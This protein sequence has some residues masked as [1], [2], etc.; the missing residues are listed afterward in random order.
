MSMTDTSRAAYERYCDAEGIDT[1]RADAHWKAWAKL[2]TNINNAISL[3]KG[4]VNLR[5][6]P[7]G[8]FK[9]NDDDSVVLADSQFKRRKVINIYHG[10]DMSV[11]VVDGNV[12]VRPI[13]DEN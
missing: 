2:I 4:D 13:A 10:N 11:E 3:L 8:A 5:G 6:E 12:I 7:I 1:G 9:T